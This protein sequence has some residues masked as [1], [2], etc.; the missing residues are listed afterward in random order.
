MKNK[1]RTWTEFLYGKSIERCSAEVSVK[2]TNNLRAFSV[3][4]ITMM[5]IAIAFGWIMRDIFTFNTEFLI[6]WAYFI[7]M[8][9]V[10]R[11]SGIYF[12]NATKAFYLWLIPVMAMGIIIGTFGDPAQPSI[13]IM[14]FLCVLPMFILDK[15]WRIILFILSN[16]AIYTVC[17][18]VSKTIE[19]FIADMIDLV[20]FTVLGLGVNC[21]I[22][23]DRIDNVEYAMEMKIMAETDVLTELYNRRAGEE[24]IRLLINH[25]KMGMFLLIDLDNFKDINDIYGHANGDMVLKTIAA[26]LKQSFRENDVVMRFG[27][28]EF[29]V[30]SQ[31]LKDQENAKKC[32][33]RMML[34]ISDL[35]IPDIPDYRFSVSVGVTFTNSKDRKTFETAYQESD[36]ALYAAKR[37]GKNSYSFFGE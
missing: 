12:K 19:M 27:G 13:T 21:L 14:V 28:D 17:C 10:I 29:M 8:Y 4:G 16:A 1:Q 25:F 37:K 22:L 34:Q 31:N 20:L 3:L 36:E 2:N 7:I 26:C 9:L 23:R 15:P 35:T 24:R 6:M 32:I 5:S 18:Y 30:F 33:D 11:F